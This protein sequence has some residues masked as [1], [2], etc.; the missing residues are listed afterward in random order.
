MPC[1]CMSGP[2]GADTITFRFPAD[3]EDRWPGVA[4]ATDRLSRGGGRQGK[5]KM[6]EADFR[7]RLQP[8]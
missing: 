6:S 5:G 4:G 1:A 7:G 3:W 8:G 2:D